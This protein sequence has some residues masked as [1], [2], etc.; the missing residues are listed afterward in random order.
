MLRPC[1]RLLYL[2]LLLA[3]APAFAAPDIADK[4]SIGAGAGTDHKPQ[5][6]LWFND[7]TWWAVMYDGTNQR[8]WKFEN[9][10][11]VKQTYADA[12]VDAR[13]TSR[14]DVLWDGTSL[15]VLMWHDALPK[16]SK[17][18]YD[19][20]TQTYQRLPGFPV[21]IA[22]PGAECMV[23]DKDSTG[24][25][26]ASFEL[27]LQ[28]HVIWTTTP[29]HLTWNTA[30]T[31]I[32]TSLESDDITATVAFGGDK[33][34][35]FW[36]DQGHEAAWEFGFR[37]HRDADPP[38]VWQPI[39]I[40]DTG[41]AVDDH[42]HATADASGRVYVTAKDLYNHIQLYVRAPGGGWTR[43]ASNINSGVCTRPI[44]MLD[45]S[46]D[47]VRVFYTD[48]ITSP[49]PIMQA[50]AP[51]STLV[52]GAP[53]VYLTPSGLSLNDVTGTKQRLSARSGV[54]AMASSSSSAYWG[55]TNLDSSG[56]T[57]EAEYPA[58]G[59]VGVPVQPLVQ[60]RLLDTDMGIRQSSISMT[61]DG[62]PITPSIAGNANEYL[63]SW[64]PSTPLQKSRV[65]TLAVAAQ[66][67][68]YPP[69]S[70]N[71]TL[72][73]RTE[74]DPVLVTRK[75]NF[76]PS[77]G[78]TPAGYEIDSGR[79][80]TFD[81]GI[82]WNKSLTAK[83]ANVNPDIRLDTWVERKNSST[84]ATWSC[85]VANGVYRVSLAAGSPSAAGKQRVQVE[86]DVL[87][88]NQ[89]TTAGQ[90]LF[91]SDYSV[92]V[93]D[94]QLDIVIGGA[95]GSTYTQLCFL[96]FLYE[97]PPPSEPPPS[98]DNDPAPRAVAGLTATRAGADVVLTWN[99]V[100]EDTTGAVIAVSRYHVYR[101]SSP[102]FLPD[103]QNHSN[104]V[105][106]IS[107]TSFT[108]VGAMNAAGDVYYLV[109]AERL[110]G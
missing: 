72:R 4:F 103:R 68:A 65:Y 96:D 84:K 101:G 69:H 110:S 58:D 85:D 35:V 3:A 8:I 47:L 89:S 40:V 10:T 108:D 43:V 64:T 56:P 67:F 17:Y 57:V 44:V 60:I 50:I 78:A 53:Q 100:T 75:I 45:D 107:S 49:N 19:S 86:S 36:S 11:F 14:A 37:V 16:F 52:F 102:S 76:Q 5:S 39:E 20:S 23:I 48:W 21:D 13:A 59:E 83:R 41:S 66:D 88:V 15:F 2:C 6:K 27:N 106:L 63:L 105:G 97:G 99:A 81:S 93:R 104:R 77:S 70:T 92:V 91:V 51:R 46:N 29:D 73:F 79:L 9:G 12:A 95:G 98:S 31:V 80:Y 28:V 62:A 18:S 90:F 7:G 82:G 71:A 32:A 74:M 30:G 87:L 34:G 25:V 24:R 109:T 1:A 22:I 42:M 54:M 33:L 26:W 61:L 38:E 55:F 94:G